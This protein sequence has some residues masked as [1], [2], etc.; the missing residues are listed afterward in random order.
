[1]CDTQ[2]RQRFWLDASRVGYL[3]PLASRRLLVGKGVGQGLSVAA[4]EGRHNPSFSACVADVSLTRGGYVN[5]EKLTVCADVGVVV[6]P[7]GAMAQIEG[8]LLWGLSSAMQESATLEKGRLKESN[9][10]S[11]KWQRNSDL[12][13]L[14]IHLVE[15]GVVPSGI[16]E[17]TMSLVAPA[18]CNAI[19]A[20]TGKRLRS[21]PLK[22][23]FPLG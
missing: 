18:V 2:L 6:N 9:F 1:M 13:E 20:L 5:V 3:L 10:D 21:L 15:N 22:N 7:E 8:S 19:A 16:G 11:Y 17:N 14:D 4:A 12:P 23:A